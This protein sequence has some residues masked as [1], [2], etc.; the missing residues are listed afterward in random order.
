MWQGYTE[1]S[2]YPR[3][4]IKIN[5]RITHGEPRRV[6]YE[7]RYGSLAKGE[8][9]LSLCHQAAMLRDECAPGPCRHRQCVEPTHMRRMPAK[10]V[11]SFGSQGQRRK[12]SDKSSS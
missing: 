12:K 11:R 2:G 8:W 1:G 9:L 7:E 10:Q 3:L 5:G 6:L 4:T